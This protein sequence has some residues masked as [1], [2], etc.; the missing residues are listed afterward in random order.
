MDSDDIWAACT[1][2]VWEAWAKIVA[3]ICKAR[4]ITLVYYVPPHL[5]MAKDD[6]R[7]IFGPIYIERVRRTFARYRNV[8]VIDDSMKRELNA[9]DALWTIQQ[10]RAFKPGY[11]FNV[12][13]KLKLARGIISSLHDTGTIL[14][15]EPSHYAGS[16]WPGESKLTSLP[17]KIEFL[18]PGL[19]LDE[20]QKVTITRKAKRA[21]S[22][23]R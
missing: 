19:V 16:A 2:D 15:A 17:S 4:G 11:L 8:V 22:N 3:K 1:D 9:R 13:G 14:D 6:Y 23:V 12:I 5:N 18:P 10:N 20:I 7:T 21:E